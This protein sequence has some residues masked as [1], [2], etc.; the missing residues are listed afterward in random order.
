[1]VERTKLSDKFDDLLLT[2]IDEAM[3]YVLGKAN[4]A[5]VYRYLEANSCSKEEIPK[6]LEVFCSALTDLI[7]NGRGQMLGAA[8][9]LEETIAESFAFK[10]GKT[11]EKRYPFDFVEYVNKLKNEQP[12]FFLV[13][14]VN[15]NL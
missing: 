4:A 8:C 2:S 7:G 6:K 1:M 11:F 15:V 5:I 12:R 14:D 3:N 13:S 9:I 10:L